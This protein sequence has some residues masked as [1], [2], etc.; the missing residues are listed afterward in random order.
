MRPPAGICVP[1]RYLRCRDGD[2]VEVSLPHSALIHA[3]RLVDCWCP[4][5]RQPGGPEA[6]E[7]AESVLED[8]EELF[9]FVPLPPNMVNIARLFSF[10]RVV[11]QLWINQTQ[12]LNEM[13]VAAGHATRMKGV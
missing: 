12:T 1:V 13:L 5:L 4:E 11:G 3:V 7:F 8:C 10:D 6:K 9:L 2:T